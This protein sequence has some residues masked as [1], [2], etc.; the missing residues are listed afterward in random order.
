MKQ[1][2]FS[3]LPYQPNNFEW[4]QKEIDRCTEYIKAAVC[5]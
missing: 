4:I 1:Y 5:F 2:K 3:Q